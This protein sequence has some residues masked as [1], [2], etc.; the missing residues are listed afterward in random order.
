MQP[1]ISDFQERNFHFKPVPRNRETLEEEGSRKEEIPSVIFPGP[2]ALGLMSGNFGNLFR[3]R[4][5]KYRTLGPHWPY[6]GA[7]GDRW[8]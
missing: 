8:G 3:G 6:R 5:P 1:H 2:G 4:M 7:C